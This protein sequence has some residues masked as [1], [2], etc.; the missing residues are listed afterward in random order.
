MQCSFP[1]PCSCPDCIPAHPEKPRMSLEAQRIAL[2]EH[3][4]WK[5]ITT[6]KSWDHQLSFMSRSEPG[7]TER[8]DYRVGR[9]CK[10]ISL[11]ARC[12]PHYGADGNAIRRLILQE[13]NFSFRLHFM[14]YLSQIVHGGAKRWA[15]QD[16]RFTATFQFCLVM[17]SPAQLAEAF[18]KAINKWT[19]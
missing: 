2:A 4:G 19:P 9:L 18:L 14:S 7:L 11:E 17:A 16:Q 5:W 15:E 6:P 3:D 13:D 8:G 1:N 12:V 10:K